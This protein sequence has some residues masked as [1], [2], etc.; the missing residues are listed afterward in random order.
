MGK[1]CNLIGGKMLPENKIEVV[2]D[3]ETDGLSATL[4]HCTTVNNLT[5]GANFSMT[6]Y[7]KMRE[8]LTN[9]DMLLIGH[10]FSC[11]D[12]PTWERILDIEIKATIVDT[13]GLSWYLYPTRQLHGLE[14]WGVDFGV[15]KPEITDWENLSVEEYI[16]RCEEDVKINT[17]LWQKMKKDLQK[18]YGKADWWLAVDYINFK[19]VCAGLKQKS[20]WKLDV[21]ECTR[22]RD[23]FEDKSV[24][25]KTQLQAAMPK[26]PVV[27]K[28]TRPKKPY[29]KDQ[30]LS[31]TGEKWKALT[32][33]YGK[34]FDFAGEIPVVNKYD[35]PNAGSPKQVKDWLTSLGWLPTIH[36]F[37][38][39]KETGEVKQIPQIKNKDTGDLCPNIVNLIEREPSLKL[40]E[41]LSILTHRKSIC[42]GFLK[43]VDDE[44]FVVA[45]VQGLTNTLRWKHKVCLNLP[46]LRKP[47]GK[48]IRGLLTCRSA[49]FELLG[50]DMSSLEDRTKQH[51]MWPHDPDYVRDMQADDFDPH[52]DIAGEAGIMTPDEVK[53]YK[54]MDNKDLSSYELNGTTYCKKVL[55]R[56][57][58]GGKG[59]NYS[60]T[61]GAGGATIAR[62]AGVPEEVGHKLHKAY[63]DRN[64]SLKAIAEECLVKQS[65]GL[66]WLWN[67][68]ACMWYYLKKDKDRFSTLNQGTGTYC[69]DMWVKEVMDRRPQLTGTFHDELILEVRVGHREGATALLN[70]CIDIV[71]GKLKLN[72]DLGC[73]VEFGVDYSCIH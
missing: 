16:H 49:D 23:F 45:R 19:M 65:N 69:F 30:S 36:N 31:A 38:R 15:P 18:L 56:K 42:D 21:D 11:Y 51:Y 53:A 28:K 27:V 71:N 46:S 12:K 13:L 1:N 3:C 64:W 73:D 39:N 44:G 50:S 34:D 57:R 17:K 10:N 29:K 66:K 70:K 68:V 4:I 59:T 55:A 47:Y 22:L 62:T 54:Y 41:D 2:A 14:S 20:R 58:H 72:R 7:G 60:A 8:Y 52:C 24:E 9:P 33:E 25:S 63:W 32:E 67:P 43:D 40:L 6:D 26:V 5:T 61:Y 37:V 48:E 35:E